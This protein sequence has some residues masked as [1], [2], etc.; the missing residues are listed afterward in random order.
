MENLIQ[1]T[2]KYERNGWPALP[3]PDIKPPM[4]WDLALITAQERIRSH[5]LSADGSRLAFIKDTETFSDVYAM[6][7]DGGWPQ[8]I[9]TGREQVAYWDDE[10]PQWS[11]D[12]SVLAFV[13][14]GHVHIAPGGG[15]LPER[16][17]DFTSAAWSPRWMP[18]SHGLI[19]SVTRHEADQLLLTDQTG[20]WP[21][22]L[23]D[24]AEG[25]HW[26]ARPSP[27]GKLVAFSL[28]RFDDLQRLDI[29]LVDLASGEIRTVYG[30]PGVR[31]RDPR[32]SPDGKW[33]A[34]I[35]QE[36]GHDD[37]WM[38]HPNG[39]HICQ[40][41]QL[42]CDIGQFAWQ[43]WSNSSGT[44]RSSASSIG[45][46]QL[47]LNTGLGRQI[48]LTINHGGAYDLALLDLANGAL[49]T[50]RGGSGVHTNPNWAP[51]GSFIT[52][53]YESPT[54]PPEIFRMDLPS[55]NTR[56]L[57][58]SMLPALAANQM[59]MPARVS[60][61]SFDGLE[62]PAFLYCPEKPNRAAIVCPHG[63]PSAQY[64]YE[65]DATAQYLVAKGYTILAPNYRGST[66]YGLKFEHA[67]YNDWGR[68]DTQ[69]CLYA[70]RYLRGLPGIDPGRLAIMGSSYGGYL[71]NCCLARDPD[72][73]FACGIAKYGDANT[74]SSW[75]LCKRELRLYS[76]IFL[77]H[78]AGSRAVYRQSSPIAEVEKVQKPLLLLHGLDDQVVPPQASEEWAAALRAHDK[79]F[80]YKTYAGE[81]H[82]FLSRATVLD[83]LA[84]IERFLDWYLLP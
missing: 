19:V 44:G 70:A 48:L 71:A 28:R 49:N 47:G 6:S 45:T 42:G 59:V 64:A 66:G 27:D 17:S 63:G 69:D 14:D 2:E 68:G 23:T 20:C 33:L 39:E 26:D 62:I 55:R 1:V 54:T 74:L 83:A 31:T 57:T 15:G 53:E 77:G 38:A 22:P 30:K 5:Q 82:G 80:E 43:P 60:Y 40:V 35:S 24:S 79:T 56:Q 37:L 50:L 11:P 3:R 36:A 52:F 32:W 51:D 18:D 65:W 41:T 76:E 29:C 13:V 10:I 75:A 8:R 25:D 34:F 16:I 73:L 4:G 67:N 7:L 84:R 81:A 72:Y 9:S 61:K 58:F 12:G 78:P 46:K 21:R